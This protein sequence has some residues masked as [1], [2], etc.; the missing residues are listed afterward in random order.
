MRRVQPVQ[1]LTGNG[2]R[3]LHRHWPL[4]WRAFDK[5]HHQ[6]IRPN[7][8][9]LTDVR[10]IQRRD[11]PR[12]TFKP[13]AEF[14][15]RLGVADLELLKVGLMKNVLIRVIFLSTNLQESSTRTNW[16]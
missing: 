4:E 12:L 5:L 7:I 8:V 10:V 9:E 15:L 2:Q 13:L 14:D 11:G 1:D 6:E 3:L 16:S